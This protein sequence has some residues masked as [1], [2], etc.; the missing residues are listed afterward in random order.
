[1]AHLS[2]GPLA[3]LAKRYVSHLGKESFFELL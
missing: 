2:A 3:D 1:M